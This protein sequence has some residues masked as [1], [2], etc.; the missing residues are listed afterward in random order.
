L[1]LAEQTA[2]FTVTIEEGIISFAND[3]TIVYVSPTHGNPDD[4][5]N[6]SWPW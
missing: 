3:R 5:G 1:R 4:H 2:V 6:G